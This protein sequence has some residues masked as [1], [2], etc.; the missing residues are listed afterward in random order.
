MRYDQEKKL[1]MPGFWY[2]LTDE[3]KAKVY[4]GTGPDYFPGWLRGLLDVVF[5]WAADP[6]MLHD[7]EYAYG[8]SKLLADLRLL[9]NCLLRGG[10]KVYRVGLSLV[11]FLSVVLFGRPAWRAGHAPL[12]S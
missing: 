6:V 4:N 1:L 5:W 3:E 10:W 8:A 7:V 11:V 12:A 2:E 9:A